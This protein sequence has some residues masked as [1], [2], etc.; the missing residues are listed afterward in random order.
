MAS[1]VMLLRFAGHIFAVLV[2]IATIAY[3]G[4]IG[5]EATK[6]ISEI[7]LGSVHNPGFHIVV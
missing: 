3:R 7:P 4:L 1:G 5:V 2:G 6:L